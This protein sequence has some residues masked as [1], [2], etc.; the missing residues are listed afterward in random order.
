M[1]TPEQQQRILR[2]SAIV[3]CAIERRMWEVAAE[4]RLGYASELGRL[5]AGVLKM[6]EKL[7]AVKEV[8]A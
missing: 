2:E 7:T 1:P 6:A 4:G 8:A 5:K 3:R